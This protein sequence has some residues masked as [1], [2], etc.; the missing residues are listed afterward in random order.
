MG[1]E[2]ATLCLLLYEHL[3]CACILCKRQRKAG[4]SRV[5]GV[6]P[7]VNFCAINALYGTMSLLLSVAACA[8]AAVQ[9]RVREPCVLPHVQA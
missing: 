5:F 2:D 4:A 3:W 7:P 6:P 9:T 1:V 8:T